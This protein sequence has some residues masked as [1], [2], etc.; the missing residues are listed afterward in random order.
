MNGLSMVAS[1]AGMALIL[2][3][4]PAPLDSA[5]ARQG[6]AAHGHLAGVVMA[7]GDSKDGKNG[8]VEI[9][10]DG[11]E[12]GRR[13]W[14]VAAAMGGRPRSRDPRRH[15][16]SRDRCPRADRMGR[17]GRRQGHFQVRG[18][19]FR[20]NDANQVSGLDRT[21][22]RRAACSRSCR[23]PAP[24]SPPPAAPRPAAS[25]RGSPRCSSTAFA[26]RRLIGSVVNSTIAPA[27]APSRPPRPRR[28]ARPP[29]AGT[30]AANGSSSAGSEIISPPAFRNRFSRPRKWM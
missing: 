22:P 23:C 9:K 2:V 10:A 17:C 27:A 30:A 15:S 11:E 25:R 6:Q 4:L 18:R 12:K 13:Y 3:V 20:R 21:Q 28:A 19:T 26:S 5:A 1:S 7:K 24:G 29:S 14:P 16:Q 8:W